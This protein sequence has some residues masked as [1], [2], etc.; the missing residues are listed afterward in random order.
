VRIKAFLL[1][2]FPA[3]FLLTAGDATA[4]QVLVNCIKASGSSGWIPDSFT[5]AREGSSK[6]VTV[7]DPLILAFLKNPVTGKIIRE[8]KNKTVLSWKVKGVRDSR[9]STTA[10][11]TFKAT[12]NTPDMS[13][14]IVAN[15]LGFSDVFTGRGKCTVV[16]ASQVKELASKIR[17]AG[18]RAGKND[19]MLHTLWKA[20]Q[21]RGFSCKLG[22]P[23]KPYDWSLTQVS[24][25]QK[26]KS[27]IASI[28]YSTRGQK[29]KLKASAQVAQNEKLVVYSWKQSSDDPRGRGFAEPANAEVTYRLFVDLRSG[30][31]SLQSSAHPSRRKSSSRVSAN[32]K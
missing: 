29:S 27:K 21:N 2:A 17:S 15:P 7:S 19:G 3:L 23:R 14:K 16:P 18:Q 1:A 11:L 6:Q 25:R 26:A 20:G 12:I 4:Q 9:G 24:I 31:A 22:Q 5:Y 30:G 8:S 10:A 32:C 28:E 13:Y